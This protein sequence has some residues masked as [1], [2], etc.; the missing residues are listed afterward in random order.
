MRPLGICSNCHKP[1]II[2]PEEGFPN[3]SSSLSQMML[4]RSGESISET[5]NLDGPVTRQASPQPPKQEPRKQESN[6]W[7]PPLASKMPQRC[8][9]H[10]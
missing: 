9:M 1:N 3:T 8:D 7:S 4:K 5:E 2:L 10:V 6:H